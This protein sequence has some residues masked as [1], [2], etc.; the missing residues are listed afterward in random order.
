MERG[1]KVKD[2]EAGERWRLLSREGGLLVAKGSTPHARV[3]TELPAVAKRLVYHTSPIS[4][5]LLILPPNYTKYIVKSLQLI[6][7]IRGA[8]QWEI[9]FKWII[10]SRQ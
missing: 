5:Q 3:T 1:V 8:Y 6:F 4:L 10:P 7:Q 2:V 9:I